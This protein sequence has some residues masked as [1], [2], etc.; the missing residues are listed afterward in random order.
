MNAENDRRQRDNMPNHRDNMP[1]HRDNMPNHRDNM[2]NHRENFVSNVLL[3][4]KR[5]SIG[6]AHVRIFSAR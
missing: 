4:Y 2:P 5:E 1:N 3:L 6:K